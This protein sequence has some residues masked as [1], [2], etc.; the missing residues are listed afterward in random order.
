MFRK[1]G[2]TKKNESCHLSTERP[3]IKYPPPYKKYS[4]TVYF[5]YVSYVFLQYLMEK[6][7]CAHKG[8]G[9]AG[10]LCANLVRWG[11]ARRVVRPCARS[12]GWLLCA[13]VVC[14]IV[15]NGVCRLRERRVQSLVRIERHKGFALF[16]E[17]LFGRHKGL[18]L[19]RILFH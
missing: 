3:D 4:C 16:S 1:A 10:G 9:C 5:L 12:V 17:A 15:R 14:S 18:S 7:P 19:V 8:W 2:T 6:I 11:C 13:V